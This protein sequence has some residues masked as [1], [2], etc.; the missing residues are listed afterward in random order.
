MW[1]GGD[2]PMT[3]AYSVIVW[4]A[5]QRERRDE[6]RTVVGALSDFKDSDRP[7]V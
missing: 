2:K 6:T 1:Q 5:N 4:G 7:P 3:T